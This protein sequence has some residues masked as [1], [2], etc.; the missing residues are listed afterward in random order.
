MA[1]SLIAGMELAFGV[2]VLNNARADG[3][4]QLSNGDAVCPLL[5]HLIEMEFLQPQHRSAR[6]GTY[7]DF[8]PI[9]VV[10]PTYKPRPD[11]DKSGKPRHTKSGEPIPLRAYDVVIALLRTCREIVN[12][13]DIDREGQRIVDELL[14]HVNIDPGG[15]NKPVWRLP[16]VSNRAEDI[17]KLVTQL[18]RNSDPKWRLRGTEALVR[19]I[20]DAATGL[21]GSMALQEVTGRANMSVGRV[22]TPVLWLVH[23]RDMAVENFKPRN[24]YVP[25]ITLSDGTEMRWF[26]REGAQGQPGFDEMGRI[27]DKAMAQQIVERISRGLQG[28]VTASQSKNG[29]A[30]APLPF[31]NASL[32]STAAKRYGMTP[33]EAEKAAQTLYER[34]KAISYVG[35]DCQFL[36]TSMLADARS[37][38]QSLARLMPGKAGGADLSLRSAAWNDAKVDEHY[39][40][41]PTGTLPSAASSDESNVFET[42]CKRY[43]AQFYPAHEFVTHS[44]AALFG[45]DEFRASRREVVRQGWKEV[46]G[47]AE[48]GGRDAQSSDAQEDGETPAA[49]HAHHAKETR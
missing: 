43:I 33:K 10:A 34:H 24:Y 17:A 39:A 13:G 26:R 27:I 16:L 21:N 47:D 30:P 3:Y 36:P 44:L 23:E 6:L 46:E 19:Q 37:T 7:F 5:G 12:A 28:T 22:Q 40:I 8:L 25:V 29:S 45:A 32:A 35:T 20:L 18:E 11:S 15:G 31:S 9:K 2:K 42:V 4:S 1:Q 14:E 48:M 49:E 38:L 41:V